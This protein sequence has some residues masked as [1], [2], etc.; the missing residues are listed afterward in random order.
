M[1]R[2]RLRASPSTAREP[3]CIEQDW[4]A[5]RTL[6]YERFEQS[7]VAGTVMSTINMS[8]DETSERQNSV[9]RFAHITGKNTRNGTRVAMENEMKAACFP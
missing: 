9:F 1:R 4:A 6:K 7:T 3:R 8:E 2:V 5:L